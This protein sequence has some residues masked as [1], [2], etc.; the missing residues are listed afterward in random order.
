MTTLQATSSPPE[1]P[2][3][4]LFDLYAF[5]GLVRVM[6]PETEA[7]MQER[8]ERERVGDDHD[9]PHARPWF[10]SFHGSEFPG[11]PANACKRYLLYRMMNLPKTQAT[12][13]WV[14]TTGTIGKAGE[15]DIARAW[16]EG[17]RMLSV[18]EDAARPDVFQL[19]FA[20]PI[21]WMT[22]STDLPILPP[23]W[24]RPHIV[25]VKGKADEV[26]E[27]MLHGRLLAM[28]DGTIK[29]IGRRPDR[30]HI[31]Q[32][33]AT[34]GEAHDYDWGTVAVC[35]KCWFIYEA[36]IFERLTGSSIHPRSDAAG[37]CPRC[38]DYSSN[39]QVFKLD[40]PVSG[41]I[42][43]WS[44]SWPRKTISFFYEYDQAF[45]ERGRRILAETR[46]HFI[47]DVLPDRPDHFQWSLE[48]CKDCT[49]KPFC[50]ADAGVP[51]RLRKPRPELIVNT[52]SESNGVQYAQEQ[53]PGY[54]VEAVRERVF[55]EWEA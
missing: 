48:P 23:G 26:V 6:E 5:L 34:I 36:D 45:M 53:R 44:R 49:F 14:S 15:L 40:P 2:Y 32:L 50:R 17:G 29:R 54:S 30:P 4:S 31:N 1:I 13:P 42:Y 35:G 10:V 43:Y 55:A 33:K 25:E 52:L 16:Y 37:W 51:G 8:A 20:N 41:E 22:V 47:D 7:L 21:L 11:E 24:R 3:L 39:G 18:P 28:A 27:E 46:Q 9:S 38:R 12:P 19:G